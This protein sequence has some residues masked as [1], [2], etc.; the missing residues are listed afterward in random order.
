MVYNFGRVCLSVCLYVSDTIT[1]KSLDVG[2]LF[3]HI[4]YI[5]KEYRLILLWRSSAQGQ[6]QRAKKVKITYSPQCKTV[7]SNKSRS[8]KHTAMMFAC[9]MECELICGWSC[10]RLESNLAVIKSYLVLILCHNSLAEVAAALLPIVKIY[11]TYN[12]LLK[13]NDW[14]HLRAVNRLL[15]RQ[16]STSQT[17]SQS[18]S[19]DT[20]ECL[21]WKCGNLASFDWADCWRT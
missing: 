13:N 15:F 5:S 11:R 7:I 3:S 21:P 10:L 4:W 17:R 20:V 18:G 8:T 6:G 2:S 19:W 14:C 12:L 16:P 9:S 1:F